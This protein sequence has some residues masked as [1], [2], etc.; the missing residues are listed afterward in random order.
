[1]AR[2]VYIETSIVSYLTA[3]PTRDLVAAA[4]QNTTTRWWETHRE[5]FELFTS[6]LTVE[7]AGQGHPEAVQRRLAVLADIPHL[8]ISEAV[9]DLATVLLA[10]DALPRKASDDAVHVAVSA[11]HAIDYL[12]TWNCRHIDN[13]E[14]KPLIRSICAIQGYKCPE[15]CTPLELMG[16]DDEG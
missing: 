4:W 8:S 11:C 9:T 6:Q 14:T 2:T 13:A 16:E 5:H 7:E 12:L 10:E 15:I 1:M 3:R